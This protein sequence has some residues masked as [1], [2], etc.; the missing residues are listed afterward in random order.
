M[1]MHEMSL[2]ASLLNIIKEEMAKA[3]KTRLIRVTLR[4]GA[5]SNVLPEALSTAFELLT[6]G[7][8]LAGAELIMLEEPARLA[9][10]GCGR[11]FTPPHRRDLFMPCPGCGRET[12]HQ[13]ISGKGLY[14]E[15]MEVN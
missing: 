6:E 1:D 8:D 5:L 14:I 9:C 11:E 12:G 7:T 4:Y 3:G 13:V 10:A 15:S 2:G